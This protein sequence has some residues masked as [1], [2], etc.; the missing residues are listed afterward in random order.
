MWLSFI[1]EKKKVI[2]LFHKVSK[3]ESHWFV[4]SALAQEI[5]WSK[6]PE[7]NKQT[8]IPY[9]VNTRKLIPLIY[10]LHG[11]FINQIKTCHHKSTAWKQQIIIKKKNDLIY[12]R[13]A[14]LHRQWTFNLSD[15]ALTPFSQMMP[16][17][18]AHLIVLL[19]IQFEHSLS[20]IDTLDERHWP[21]I[22]QLHL[23]R[24]RLSL[25][26]SLSS[27]HAVSPLNQTHVHVSLFL[28]CLLQ[29]LASMHLPSPLL[30]CHWRFFS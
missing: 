29:N 1:L 28:S 23:Y 9:N 7:R 19:F 8:N 2:I 13:H 5:L 16:Q 11:V 26:L 17:P 3:I 12:S 24:D 15:G 18:A 10:G 20:Q 22:R 6:C 25:W 21:K 30:F 27:D 4:S 14:F